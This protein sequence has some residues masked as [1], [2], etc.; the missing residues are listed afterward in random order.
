MPHA[1][2]IGYFSNHTLVMLEQV[3]NQVYLP[4][5]SDPEIFQADL[6]RHEQA[7]QVEA[8][9]PVS[10]E[11]IR[12]TAHETRIND[13]LLAEFNISIQRFASQVTQTVQQVAGD[14]KLRIPDDPD[15]LVLL[16]SDPA[17][18]LDMPIRIQMLDACAEEW[19]DGIQKALAKEAKKVPHGHSPMAEIEFWRDRHFSL[20]ALYEKLNS[21]LVSAIFRVLERAQTTIFHN[22]EYH[23]SELHKFHAEAK[24]NVKFLG[25][26]E[27]HFKNIITGTLSSVQDA[28]PSLMN[29]VRMV[30][31]ISRHYNK[32]E[33]MVPLMARIAWELA[34]KIATVVNV[35]T[36][37]RL[38]PNESKRR[39]L[40][41]K[42][43]LEAWSKNYFE[44][45]EKIEQSGRDQRWEFDRKK[46]FEQTN[47]MTQRCG[48]L[49]EIAEVLEQFY[50]IFGPELKGN[51]HFL[52]PLCALFMRLL[53]FDRVSI[54]IHSI[55]IY[56]N[57]FYWIH[58]LSGYGGYAA[59]R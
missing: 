20:S 29:A 26:L 47:Y 39:I 31:I 12:N 1:L 16:K 36:V 57:I 38:A 14:V 55:L 3:I 48:D 59:N 9:K 21:P 52:D 58:V 2:E 5:L 46:L 4:L 7:T 51:C 49:Y 15:L 56:F 41:G 37:L 32:D 13:S 11:K 44:T 25:T 27:R 18:I 22:L 45:R 19:V 35:K 54:N 43:L 40:D 28:L 6:Q 33:R 53:D 24:D 23:L 8:N 42:N 34:N 30:W 17:S 10:D 50:G